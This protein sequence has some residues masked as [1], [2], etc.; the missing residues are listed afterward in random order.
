[1]N[2]QVAPAEVRKMLPEL[3]KMQ[4]VFSEKEV[5]GMNYTFQKKIQTMV[6]FYCTFQKKIQTMVR[7]YC[8]FQKKIQT[9]VRNYYTNIYT[10]I[11]RRY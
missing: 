10:N 4:S 2:F 6:R 3:Q 8:T 1:L 9:M 5:T 7:N 11:R